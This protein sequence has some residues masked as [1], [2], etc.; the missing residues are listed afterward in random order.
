MFQDT[1][2]PYNSGCCALALHYRK[3]TINQ[4]E[5]KRSPSSLITVIEDIRA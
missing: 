5:P 3:K 2:I 4:S 1:R